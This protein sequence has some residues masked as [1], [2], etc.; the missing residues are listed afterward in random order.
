MSHSKPAWNEIVLINNYMDTWSN[1]MPA[2]EPFCRLIGVNP[3]KLTKE[4]SYLVEAEL[5]TRICN[6]LM[7]IFKIQYKDDPLLLKTNIEM[8]SAM[9]DINF[10][11]LIIRDILSTDEYSIQGIA[12]YTDTHEDVV[13]EVITGRNLSPSATF[14]R[15][16]IELHRSVKRDV[17]NSII[18]KI[19]TQYLA[20]I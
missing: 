3:N 17:Y 13:C 19:T 8:E 16:I 5:F 1:T 6:E 9:F 7:E 12:I 18:K 4:E 10:I 14:F 15:R 2:T 11:R 20:A